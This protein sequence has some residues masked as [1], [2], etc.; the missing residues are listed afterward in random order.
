LTITS[1]AQLDEFQRGG[2]VED[3]DGVNGGQRGQHAARS[4]SPRWDGLALQSTHGCIAVNG[5]NQPVT[6]AARLL[7][8]RDVAYV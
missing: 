5:H 8:Y 7:Q 3:H 2:L 1:V 6:E 4:R